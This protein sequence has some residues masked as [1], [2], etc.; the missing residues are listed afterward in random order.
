MPGDVAGEEWSALGGE[1][2]SAI[3]TGR[4][5]SSW[6]RDAILKPTIVRL[7]GDCSRD[8][9]LDIGTGGGWLF[10]EIRVG[11]PHACDIATPEQVPEGVRFALADVTQLP[12]ADRYFDALVASVVLCYCSDL[13]R[14][15]AEM[16]RVTRTG[17]TAVVA[18]VHPYFYRTGRA[19]K[20][21][22]FRVTTDLSRPRSF[23]IHIGERVGPFTYHLYAPGAYVNAF[24]DTGW[25]L[26][27]ME[28]GFIPRELYKA[29][30]AADRDEVERSTK[31]PL[32]TFMTFERD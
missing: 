4:S 32:F 6:L 26:T 11:E 8:R 15:A 14:A 16:A 17:G 25:R 28:D 5:S 10:E 2:R 22:S 29:R 7:L 21:D 27:R 13:T 1:Y 19:E 18:L 20:D 9:V 23:P 12:H 30:F 31:V 24:V 3:A